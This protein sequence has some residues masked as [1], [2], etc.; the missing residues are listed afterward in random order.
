M[1]PK[2]IGYLTP[3]PELF[4]MI[5][6][7]QEKMEYALWEIRLSVL[8]SG[9]IF[10]NAWPFSYIALPGF[11]VLRDHWR[12]TH[13]FKIC[14]E[15]ALW[16]AFTLTFSILQ[17]APAPPIADQSARVKQQTHIFGLCWTNVSKDRLANGMPGFS[18]CN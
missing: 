6:H 2:S 9:L 17:Q 7:I 4:S 12:Q 16:L 15:T 3:K 8:P 14:R 1:S 10:I 18:A 5:G 11:H 13:V